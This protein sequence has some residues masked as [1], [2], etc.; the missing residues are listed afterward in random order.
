MKLTSVIG[1]ALAISTMAGAASAATYSATDLGLV[2]DGSSA[3]HNFNVSETGAITSLDIQV[4]F[5]TCGGFYTSPT[6]ACQVSGP[7]YNGELALT[8]TSALGTVIN[9][10]S[11]DDYTSQNSGAFSVLFTDSAASTLGGTTTSGSFKPV[12]SLSTLFGEN[13]FG[14]WALTISDNFW[15]DPKRLDSFQLNLTTADA[16]VAPVP[17]PAGLPLLLAGL[18]GLAVLR[19]RK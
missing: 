7:A 2:A 19:R 6:G 3:S 15:M 11:T 18:G 13:A 14:Q 9:L 10:I 5:S 1:A 16:A 4:G 8:L 12:D 17:L